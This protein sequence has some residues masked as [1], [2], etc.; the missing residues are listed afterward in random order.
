MRRILQLQRLAPEKSTLFGG[1][2]SSSNIQ[3]CNDTDN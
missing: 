2:S 3:C 1:S